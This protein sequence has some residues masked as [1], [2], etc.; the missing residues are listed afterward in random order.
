METE[1]PLAEVDRLIKEV[2]S[3]LADGDLVAAERG[4]E[5][6]LALDF[7]NR[8]VQGALKVLRFWDERARIAGAVE[9]PMESGE[10]LLS[11]WRTYRPFERDADGITPRLQHAVRRYVFGVAHKAFASALT[12]G[13]APDSGVL[14]RMGRCSKMRGEYDEALRSL[15]DAVAAGRESGEL[16]AELADTNALVDR[17]PEAKALFRE[18]FFVDPLGVDIDYLESELALRLIREVRDQ[19][20]P[21]DQLRVWIPVYGVVLDVFNVK[22]ELRSVEYGRLKQSIYALEREVDPALPD[23]VPR[24]LNRYFWLI[25]YYQHTEADR[26]RIEDVLLNIKTL[27]P[28]I[29]ELYTR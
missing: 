14:L 21:E 11:H 19:G 7:E 12:R 26:S 3:L 18:A 6:A 13:G 2:C 10:R 8:E 4:A 20:I 5:R 29:Y 27:D 25:D 1:S 23:R 22:R 28:K 9:T 24:L 15:R 17:V 16:L